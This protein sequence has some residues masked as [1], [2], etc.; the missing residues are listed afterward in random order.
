MHL[1]KNIFNAKLYSSLFWTYCT[2]NNMCIL[3]TRCAAVES[4]WYKEHDWHFY[5]NSNQYMQLMVKKAF[6]F[7]Q[8]FIMFCVI[9]KLTLQNVY[10]NVYP[11]TLAVF[12]YVFRKLNE[13]IIACSL[14]FPQHYTCKCMSSFKH[15][16]IIYIWWLCPIMPCRGKL[17]V[18]RAEITHP[19]NLILSG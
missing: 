12:S 1:Y 4:W 9:F 7:F 3:I 19:D 13:M 11:H 5:P 8:F 10:G 14:L 2:C 6:C 15:A 18:W 17:Q 16:L